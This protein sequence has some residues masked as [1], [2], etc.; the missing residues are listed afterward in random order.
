MLR[1]IGI[2]SWLQ[3]GITICVVLLIVVPTLNEPSA[4]AVF[5]GY[6]TLLVVIS[7]LT[8]IGSRRN[9]ETIS[10]SFLGLL[11]G[12]AILSIISIA[13]IPGSHFD[14]LSI[15]YRHLLF[16]VAF[17][18]L[19]H[20]NR[21]LSARWKGSVLVVF[22]ALNLAHLVPALIREHRPVAG[23]SAYNPN[24][25]GTFLLIGLAATVSVAAFGVRRAWRI[26]AAASALVLFFGIV[27]TSSRGALL[28]A[29][30]IVGLG[31]IRAGNRIPRQV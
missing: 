23:F 30:A 11:S 24:Y 5:F 7:I 21:S 13:G 14:A 9:A 4:A 10:L 17:L 12:W 15:F 18:C 26:A 8:V 19:A 27:Q 29:A 22:V 16:F 3:F 6:R 1:K 25:F 31:A 20:Y 2:E 28:A